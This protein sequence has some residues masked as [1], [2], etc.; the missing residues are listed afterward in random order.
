MTDKT[1]LN[2]AELETILRALPEDQAEEVIQMIVHKQE[3]SGPFPPPNVLNSYEQ[4][5]EGF[6]DRVMAL[7]EKQQKHRHDIESRSVDAAISAEKR[8]QNYALFLSVLIIIGSIYLIDAGKEW[9]GSI[10]AG[11]TLTGLAYIFITGRK[12]A[13]KDKPKS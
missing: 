2:P 5:Q 13:Q 11:G 8:G 10:L 12:Q 1:E 6:A 9:S 3:F 4:V 7:T